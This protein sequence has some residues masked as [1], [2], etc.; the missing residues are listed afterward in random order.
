[1]AKA[2]KPV[3]QIKRAYEPPSREDGYRVLIDRLWPRGIKKEALHLDEWDKSLAPSGDLRKWFDHRDERFEEFSKRY[4]K[5][6]ESQQENLE[7]L[8]KI[9]ASK[10]LT[11]V[12]GARNTE[13]NN[14]VVLRE[15]LQKMRA[16][17][18]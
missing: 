18:K 8:K 6:L 2:A 13:S 9:A 12:Y 15:V 1:M 5:E 17:S 14:A 4:K 3:I 10:G 16:A 11:L 7:R